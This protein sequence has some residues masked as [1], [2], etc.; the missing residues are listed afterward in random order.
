MARIN[1]T[2][3]G[4]S[5]GSSNN[6]ALTLYDGQI[7]ELIQQMRHLSSSMNDAQLRKILIKNATPYRKA[8]KEKAPK[9]RRKH[10]RYNTPK[11]SG[12]LKAPKG[13]GVK[14]ATYHPGNLA[15]SI[16]VVP[17]KNKKVLVIGPKRSRRGFGSSG[18]EFGPG[19]GRFDGYY[20]TFLKNTSWRDSAWADTR[21]AI[22][23]GIVSDLKSLIN[24]KIKKVA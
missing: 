16:G 23:K 9:S 5:T 10:H 15:G 22:Y 17:T 11:L 3:G 6:V 14:I 13:Y 19:T 21:D 4:V 24:Q 18:K 1:Q 8:A 12:R 2:I 7:F 20:A